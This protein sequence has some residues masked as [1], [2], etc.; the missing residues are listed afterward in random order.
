MSEHH[1]NRRA[2]NTAW[3]YALLGGA[4]ITIAGCGSSS[5]TGNSDGN[6][7]NNLP[8]GAVGGSISSNHGHVATILAAELTA[9][10]GLSLNIQGSASHT[11]IVELSG[12]D[13]VSIR[14]GGRVSKNSSTGDGH[15]HTVTFN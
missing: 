14:G 10:N 2:F 8:P 7:G 13:V 9:G 1:M 5:P 11:H 15:T 6:S 12:G 4:T 3:A